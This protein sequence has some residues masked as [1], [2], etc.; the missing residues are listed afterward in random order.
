MNPTRR[1]LLFQGVL[2]LPVVS[3]CASSEPHPE[4]ANNVLF[5]L[6]PGS[7]GKRISWQQQLRAEVAHQAQ[8]PL[9]LLLQV[10]ANELLVA[11]VAAG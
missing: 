9:D 11:L 1:Y 5:A 6:P 2:T 10:D 4:V 7:L 8:P 3:G